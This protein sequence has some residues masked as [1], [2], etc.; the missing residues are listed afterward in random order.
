MLGDWDDDWCSRVHP[1]ACQIE[2]CDNST[3][4]IVSDGSCPD[5]F[6]DSELKIVCCR[7]VKK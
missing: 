1:G 5:G 3:G 7:I 2:R 6:S 4:C